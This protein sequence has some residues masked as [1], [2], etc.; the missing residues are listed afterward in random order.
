MAELFE[1][2]GRKVGEIGELLIGLAL[3]LLIGGLLEVLFTDTPR[4]INR[5][6][7]RARPTSPG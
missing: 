6:R 2:R 1:W 3:L 4:T 5:T 7:T